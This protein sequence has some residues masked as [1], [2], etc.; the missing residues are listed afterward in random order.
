MEN[1]YKSSFLPEMGKYGELIV[2]E[3]PDYEDDDTILEEITR[4][5]FSY[6]ID[7]PLKFKAICI[8]LRGWYITLAYITLQTITLG[9]G[10]YLIHTCILTFMII[11]KSTE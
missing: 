8:K 4:V 9:L 6:E 11:Q 2:M 3:Y 10:T 7:D 5:D 1:H